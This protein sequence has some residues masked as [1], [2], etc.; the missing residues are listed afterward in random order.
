MAYGNATPP[1]GAPVPSQEL[2][3]ATLFLGLVSVL[4]ISRHGSSIIALALGRTAFEAGAVAVFSLNIAGFVASLWLLALRRWAWRLGLGYGAVQ[5]VLRSYTAATDLVPGLAGRGGSMDLLGALGQIV[6]GLVFL[7]VLAF[8]AG[9]DTRGLLAARE[10]Y[11]R[12]TTG[13][14]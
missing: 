8:L 9:K 14:D 2:I 3:G 12:A 13:R 1:E 5:V 4:S 10:D 7:V 6:L 11:R